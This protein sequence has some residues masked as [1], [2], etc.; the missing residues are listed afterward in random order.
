MKQLLS[1]L[2]ALMGLTK[3]CAET[4]VKATIV[5]PIDIEHYPVVLP[6]KNYENVKTGR[7]CINGKEIPCQVDDL[8]KDGTGDEL[9]FLVN[10]KRKKPLDAIITLNPKTVVAYPAMTYAEMV[11]RN[12]KIKEKNKQ[13]IYISA[14]TIDKATVNPYNVL[15]HHG[16]AFENEL[17]AMRIYMDKRQTI[18]LYGKYNKGLE[19]HDT[20][21]YTSEK[22]KSEGYGDDILWVGNSF[23]L[24]ALRGWN[25]KD[26]TFVD[27]VAYRTQRIVTQGPVRTI[28]EIEDEGWAVDSC[29]EPLNMTLR[30]TLYACHRDVDVHV[31]FRQVPPC[32]LFST[33]LVNIKGSSEFTDHNGLRGCW[34]TAWPANDTINWKKETVGLGIC[35]PQKY[36]VKELS[37]TNDNYGYVI[38]PVEKEINYKL[39]YS[40][41]NETYGF[42]DKKSWFDYL[43]TWKKTN[44]A[45]VKITVHK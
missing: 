23:G 25:G 16:V 33:G 1:L 43:Q 10:L 19:L 21:F 3:I 40:S 30:Y 41:A 4:T 14:I 20:Q 39:T 45:V 15:H 9:C 2:F 8:D 36:I 29:H 17:I 32:Q 7:V 38:R 31:K 34:G 26:P 27:P 37:A 35:L 18:D 28:V 42:H 44:D 11:L 22:Q 12:P 24:G 13:D 6:I 5:S